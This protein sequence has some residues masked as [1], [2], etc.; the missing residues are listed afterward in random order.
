MAKGIFP[1]MSIPDITAAL[2]GWDLS[3]SQEQ[4]L[5]PTSDFVE[6][7]YYVCLQQVT[8]IS[9]D[10][11]R[12]PVQNALFA[13][14]TEEKAARVEDFNAKDLISPEKERTLILLS[15]FINFIKFTEQYCNAFVKGL[16]DRSE[17]IIVDRAQVS[18]Q[19]I[20]LE[21][22][23]GALKAKIAEDE[24]RC[25]ELRNVN[26]ALRAKMIATKEFQTAAVQ[27]VEKLKAEK[28]ALVKRKVGRPRVHFTPG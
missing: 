6:G 27:E 14:A 28:N 22:K 24:P 20:E 5:R 4:L 3:V 13:S 16:R 23:I 2:A 1:Q 21:Q 17:A 12:G 18:E 26:H 25:E 8:G 7:V 19:L 11:L 15:A 9:Q 10:S